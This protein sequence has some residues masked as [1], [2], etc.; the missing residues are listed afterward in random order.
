MSLIFT[1]LVPKGCLQLYEEGNRGNGIYNIDPDGKGN[2]SVLCDMESSGGGWT[3]FQKRFNGSV[4]FYRN[5]T[6]YQHGFGD[7]SREFWLGLEK[8]HRMS[9][10]TENVLRIEMEDFEGEQ[11]YA[12]YRPFQVLNECEQY[13]LVIGNYSGF[14]S[15]IFHTDIFKIV[16]LIIIMSPAY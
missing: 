7:L 11:R 6:E 14:Y 9:M 1:I 12:E 8:I 3:V 2:F 4:N 13:K 16:N 15:D 5:W 10:G